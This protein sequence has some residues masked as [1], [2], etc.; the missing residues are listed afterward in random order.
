[1][2]AAYATPSQRLAAWARV[3]H[4][5]RADQVRRWWSQTLARG[6][7]FSLGDRET[8]DAVRAALVTLLACRE[9]RGT[10]WVP[11]GNP[12]QYRDVWLRDGARAVRALSI[13]G[14]NREAQDLARGLEWFEWPS[15]AFLS[16]RGQLDGTG[17][18]LWAFEQAHLRPVPDTSV[19]RV[20]ELALDGTKWG[21]RQRFLGLDPR[22]PFGRLL[23]W[24][25]PR[26]NE[27]VAAQL[28]GNDAWLIAGYR[29]AAR[30]LRAAGRAADADSVEAARVQYVAEFE[31]ALTA[32][33]RAD[34]P[35][36][37]QGTGRDWGNIAACVPCG[38]VPP[39]HPRMSAL[40]ER[41]WSAAGG[42]G[43][44]FY[45]TPDSLHTYLFSDLATW[46]MLTG[47]RDA[48]E[49]MLDSLLAWRSAS[50]GIGELFSRR[51]RDWGTNAPPHA[52]AAAA[53]VSMVRDAVVYDED[54]T[55][56]LTLGAPAR[57][58]RGA[59]VK[60][61]A[62]RWGVVDVHFERRGNTASWRWS[63]VPVWTALTLPAGTTLAAVPG[64]SLRG[65]AGDTR[66]LAPPGARAARVELGGA[67]AP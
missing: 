13:T 18:A 5:R 55:L 52:T 37:W 41:L 9:R 20:A 26:D 32:T 11:I 63:P 14:F 46:A 35:P 16:Q 61:A 12:F 64:D 25:D 56:R 28:V 65:A 17:Q 4:A 30:L 67:G 42:P 51:S 53:L 8:E 10:L 44:G 36:S 45:G 31:R 60:R 59:G 6:A 43:L 54:D 24:G 48:A 15:G 1:V 7:Q 23:P 39:T 2:L 66:V 33:W 34:I 3:P 38:A 47:R 40:A 57:W 50:G 29:S 22:S 49:R 21:E 62:T 58:W 27:L 19:A